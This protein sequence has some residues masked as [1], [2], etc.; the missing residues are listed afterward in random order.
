M[1]ICGYHYDL[2]S[3][4][5]FNTVSQIKAI[6]CNDLVQNSSVLIILTSIFKLEIIHYI[7]SWRQFVFLHSKKIEKEKDS[8]YLIVCFD[9][10]LELIF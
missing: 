5:H 6:T 3:T 8:D 2:T 4:T 7:C 10:G 1:T 9:R